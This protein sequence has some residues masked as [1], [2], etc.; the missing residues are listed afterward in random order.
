M[1]RPSKSGFQ[2][3]SFNVKR[4]NI[5]DTNNLN[6]PVRRISFAEMSSGA[7]ISQNNLELVKKKKA[8]LGST[9]KVSK[10]KGLT[11]RNLEKEAGEAL[12]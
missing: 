3:G 7:S 2:F 9:F 12:L 10:G 5:P 1:H 6:A 4:D 8:N 11:T